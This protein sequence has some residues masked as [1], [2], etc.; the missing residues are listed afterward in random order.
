MFAFSFLSL[1]RPGKSE[2]SR[3]STTK[4][5]PFSGFVPVTRA[6][7]CRTSSTA[8]PIAIVRP[9]TR[10]IG[11]SAG[12]S[13]T[14]A[15]S[16][17]FDSSCSCYHDCRRPLISRRVSSLPHYCFKDVEWMRCRPSV[18]LIL[19]TVLLAAVVRSFGS[20]CSPLRLPMLATESYPVC[21]HHGSSCGWASGT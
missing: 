5:K 9:A 15:T 13:P 16:S 17:N 7:I 20:H 14:A 4:A 21:S 11:M 3:A 6:A 2:R 10:N 18:T 12:E 19:V 8:C 1:T